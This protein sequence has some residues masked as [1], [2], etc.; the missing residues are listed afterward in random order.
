[1]GYSFEQLPEVQSYLSEPPAMPVGSAGKC[2]YL[3]MG[4]RLDG[5]GRSI[6]HDLERRVPTV[7]QQELYFDECMPQMPCVYILSSGGQYVDGDRYEQCVT[8]GRGSFAHISTGAATKVASMRH[9][10]AALEQRF[11]L[12]EGAYLEFLPEPTIPARGA[13]LVT[14]THVRIDPSATL[15]YGEIFSAGRR[16]HAG[17]ERFDY[18]LL[19]VRTSAGRWDGRRLFCEKFLIRPHLH[20]PRRL[21]VMGR[22]EIF[23][24]VL[25]LAPQADADAVYAQTGAFVDARRHLA[26][27]V[28]RLPSGCGLLYKV[29]GS[30]TAAVKGQVRSFASTV[31]RQIKGVPLPPEFPWR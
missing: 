4:F 31:R 26:A 2:G 20:D 11:D 24:N 28:T 17:G 1:M 3:R 22:Y 16:W 30:D 8:M 23:A 19:S 9:N 7:V 25:L 15:L 12:E 21:G 14:A 6:M 29:L 18:D 10:F 27:A 5:A 13:R